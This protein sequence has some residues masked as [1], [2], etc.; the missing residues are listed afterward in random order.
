MDGAIRVKEA[1]AS[2]CFAMDDGICLYCLLVKR[3]IIVAFRLQ[4]TAPRRQDRE[5]SAQ[6]VL[7]PSHRVAAQTRRED[8]A[9]VRFRGPAVSR[10][11][12]NV[13]DV[14][15]FKVRKQIVCILQDGYLTI[16]SMH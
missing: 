8:I 9:D 11:R 1:E 14:N 2:G 13:P 4:H 16:R 5:E 12:V 3:R 7:A 15:R 10:F 6:G